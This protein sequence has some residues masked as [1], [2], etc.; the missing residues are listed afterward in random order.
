MRILASPLT[1]TLR[2]ARNVTRFVKTGCFCHN[3]ASPAYTLVGIPTVLM[4]VDGLRVSP[5]CPI[6]F[7]PTKTLPADITVLGDVQGEGSLLQVFP[8]AGVSAS[9]EAITR[10]LFTYTLRAKD[11]AVGV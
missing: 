6:G 7:L 4:L 5:M 2:F 10:I 1:S 11:S 9:P 3:Y 8:K